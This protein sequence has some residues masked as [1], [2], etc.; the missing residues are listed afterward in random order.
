MWMYVWKPE[1]DICIFSF[2]KYIKL[3]LFLLIWHSL[4]DSVFI[5]TSAPST[6]P[7]NSMLFPV[8][9]TPQ[10]SF[11][12]QGLHRYLLSPNLQ[13]HN[14]PLDWFLP[15]FYTISPV[16]SY[17]SSPAPM[18]PPYLQWMTCYSLITGSQHIL[19]NWQ[20]FLL[21]FLGAIFILTYLYIPKWKHSC[22]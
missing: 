17:L 19:V 22:K 14:G 15:F 20:E 1:S 10:F 2:Y 6:F 9:R 7:S 13:Y 8:P 3:K 4:G 16:H 12:P 21:R 11:I 18:P 5:V